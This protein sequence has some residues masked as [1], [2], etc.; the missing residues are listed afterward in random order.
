MM[1][2]RIIMIMMIMIVLMLINPTVRPVYD[3]ES[4]VSSR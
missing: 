1:M 3:D 4:K 2:M